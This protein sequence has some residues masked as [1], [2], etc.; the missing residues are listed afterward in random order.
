MILK[1]SKRIFQEVREG[2]N[3]FVI[4]FFYSFFSHKKERV[5]DCEVEI[6]LPSTE[7]RFTFSPNFQ[8]SVN[9]IGVLETFKLIC[10]IDH[11]PALDCEVTE[12]ILA[13]LRVEELTLI[14]CTEEVDLE[15]RR[16][17]LGELQK[18]IPHQSSPICS[19]RT[20]KTLQVRLQVEPRPVLVEA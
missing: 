9:D 16:K 3:F 1:I 15:I 8:D 17:V 6:E 10:P 19:E 11:G 13:A 4:V 2:F 20:I 14:A 12:E 5:I 7:D 18:R